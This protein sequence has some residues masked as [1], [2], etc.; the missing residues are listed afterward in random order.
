[1]NFAIL[2]L[3]GY[4]FPPRYAK[5]KHLFFDLFEVAEEDGGHIRLKKD[6]NQSLII[7]QWENIQ[8]IMC[9]LSR[10]TGTESTIVRKLNNG[11]SRSLSALHEYD[12]LIK[13]IYVLE[14]IDNSTL[15]HYVQHALNRGEAYH[16][17]NRAITSV[18]GNKF[19]G[20]N[21]YQVC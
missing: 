5:M 3:F 7:E 18:N 2:D 14:Y 17:L 20:G 11:K 4:A 1:V 6:I 9:S 10:K 21:D 12:H 8:H 16:Q 19:R 15:R 13:S